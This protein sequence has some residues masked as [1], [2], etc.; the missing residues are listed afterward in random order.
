MGSKFVEESTASSRLIRVEINPGHVACHLEL[1]QIS[2][3][4][5]DT[6]DT[7]YPLIC[8]W[9]LYFVPITRQPS[10]P[11][12]PMVRII[13]HFAWTSFKRQEILFVSSQTTNNSL[14]PPCSKNVQL[15]T[16]I[17]INFLDFYFF[18]IIIFKLCTCD[19][20]LL[21]SFFIPLLIIP[22]K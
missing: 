14:P 5:F 16:E 7:P 20:M 11:R 2:T 4:C 18:Q 22:L 17:V 10:L 3:S 12:S 21:Y 8:F 13:L 19:V 9:Q 6:Q 1:T 15:C